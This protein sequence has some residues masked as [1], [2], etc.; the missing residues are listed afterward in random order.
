MTSPLA[1][2]SPPAAYRWTGG[3]NVPV[4]FGRLSATL[5]LAVLEI[6]GTMLVFRIRP[7]W[8][9]ALVGAQS[10]RLSAGDGTVVFPVE[11]L[12]GIGVG[13]RPVGQSA[14]Y[15]RSFSRGD[16]LAAAAAAGF[17]VLPTPGRWGR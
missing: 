3:L 4:S 16:I 8:V 10:L 13:V 6:S 5:P 15:F 12:A 7:R 11:Q 2:V 17:D 1:H 14:W 9:Q